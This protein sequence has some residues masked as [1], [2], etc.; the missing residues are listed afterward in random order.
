MGLRVSALFNG[1]PLKECTQC[2]A[3]FTLGIAKKNMFLS[4]YFAI[5][6]YHT[7]DHK[8]MCEKLKNY[9]FESIF[10]I[11]AVGNSWG[12]IEK[13]SSTKGF[14]SVRP[15]TN[16]WPWNENQFCS[17][18]ILVQKQCLFKY[19]W[20]W[21]G[22]GTRHFLSSP[23]PP[24]TSL[25]PSPCEGGSPFSNSSSSFPSPWVDIS[26]WVEGFVK[27]SCHAWKY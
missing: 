3:M 11:L 19:M 22:G 25:S 10:L 16:H 13:I 27:E 12:W 26:K 9:E 1:V 14:V 18:S 4:W 7:G 8:Y 20:W 21:G 15:H 17:F 5:L 23:S 24:S 2:I 6:V